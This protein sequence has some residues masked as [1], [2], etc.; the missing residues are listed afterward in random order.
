VC[1][2]A[3]ASQHFRCDLKEALMGQYHHLVCVEAAEGLDPH[4][5]GCGLKEGEQGFTRPG[6]PN[7]MVALVCA[8]GGNMPADCSQSPLI[9]RWAGKRVLVQGDYAED[10]DIPGWDGPPLSALYSAM[11]PA[12][13]REPWEGMP[14]GYWDRIPIFADISQEARGFLEATCNVRYFDQT[15]KGTDYSYTTTHFVRVKPKAK[16][17]GNC[18]VAEYVIDTCYSADDLAW[19]KERCGLRPIDVQRVPRSGD[20]HGLLPEEITEGQRRMI[21]NLDTLEYLD[22]VKFGQVPSLAGIV[23]TAPKERCIPVLKEADPNSVYLVD[24][25]GALFCLLCH[26]QRR[27]GGDIPAN[28]EEMTAIGDPARN[29]HAR[30]FKGLDGFKGRWRGGHILGTGEIRYE[31]WPTADEVIERGTDISDLALRY[32]VAITHY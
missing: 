29:K 26:P 25:A 15:T 10:D 11:R 1:A 18:G 13:E 22:P 7:A 32:L 31:D 28:G 12:D 4:A 19:F 9:G 8:R 27:G 3:A 20:W 17:F 2:G 24:I 23:S 5:L 30:L 14:D 21:V 6:T 16:H